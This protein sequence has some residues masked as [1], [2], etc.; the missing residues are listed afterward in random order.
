MIQS[1]ILLCD[2]DS[3]RRRL[4]ARTLAALDLLT[5]YI[6]VQ[7]RGFVSRLALGVKSEDLNS[8]LGPGDDGQQEFEA[9]LKN[10]AGKHCA[11]SCSCCLVAQWTSYS[12]IEI[13]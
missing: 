6:I 8:R 11:V 12:P 9:C 10:V 1:G 2:W 4:A 5:T 3:N 13:P 7:K